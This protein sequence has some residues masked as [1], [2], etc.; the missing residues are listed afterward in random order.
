[1][2]V[3]RVEVSGSIHGLLE[4]VLRFSVSHSPDPQIDNSSPKSSPEC[5]V[6]SMFEVSCCYADKGTR[7]HTNANRK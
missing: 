4:K 7:K 6:P 5:Q 2:L 3:E 1:M